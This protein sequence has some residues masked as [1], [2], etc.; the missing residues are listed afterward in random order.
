MTASLATNFLAKQQND[1]LS[2]AL[3][4]MGGVCLLALLAQ[5]SVP[6]P[7]TPVPVTGQTLGVAFLSLLLGRRLAPITVAFYLLAGAAGLPVFSQAKA[8][9]SWGP[10]A[11]YLIGMLLASAWVGF[12][13]DRGWASTFFRAWLA[14]ASGSLIIF[15]CGLLVLSQ[16]VPS[17]SLLTAGLWPFL[18]GDFLKNIT[19]A[20]GASLCAR[21]YFR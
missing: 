16:F 8:G 11:G 6:L 5:L 3:F 1:F 18:P 4:V 10:T 15:T 17:G 7:F 12:L 14:A 20:G 9:L 19:A 21:Y 13:A 2:N